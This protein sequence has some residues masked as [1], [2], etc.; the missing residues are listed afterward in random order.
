ML[1]KPPRMVWS[2]T[3]ERSPFSHGVNRTPWDPTGTDGATSLRVPKKPSGGPEAAAAARLG[4][5]GEGVVGEEQVVAQPGQAGAPRLVLVG[6]QVAA[7][8]PRGE[9]GDVGQRVGLLEGDVAADPARRADVEVAVEVGHGARTDG[10]R[11]QVPG[12]GDDRRPRQQAELGGGGG[13]QPAEH[14][15]GRHQVGQL[16]AL[17]AGQLDRARRHRRWR[18]CRGC[19]SPSAR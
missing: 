12:A 10:G 5:G 6:H 7:R 19:P 17:Q 3:G 18:R 9:G 2:S 15:A 1:W 11:V 13:G 14:A 16:G 4:A 8:D